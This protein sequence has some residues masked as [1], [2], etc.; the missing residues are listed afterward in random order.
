M[1]HGVIAALRPM[2]QCLTIAPIEFRPNDLASPNQGIGR[3][4][5][6]KEGRK[7]GMM[8]MQARIDVPAF[9]LGIYNN[10]K[11]IEAVDRVLQKQDFVRF[12]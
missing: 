1:D 11:S 3:I 2:P 7:E 5:V 9:D 8:T 6:A 12:S 10:L 4:L